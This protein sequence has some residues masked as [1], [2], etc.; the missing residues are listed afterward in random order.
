MELWVPLV[1]AILWTILLL[2]DIQGRPLTGRGDLWTGLAW[3]WVVPFVLYALSESIAA[4]IFAPSPRWVFGV[5]LG[6]FTGL[7]CL[8]LLGWWGASKSAE[9]KAETERRA[10]TEILRRE[11]EYLGGLQEQMKEL[12]KEVDQQGDE[13]KD[14]LEK[15]KGHLEVSMW[16]IS[17]QVAE[18]PT[19]AS[20]AG[21][22]A[23]VEGLDFQDRSARLF[24]N[25]G[26]DVDNKKGPGEPDHVLRLEGKIVGVV[27]AKY[28]GLKDKNWTVNEGRVRP[29]LKLA[30]EQGVPLVVHVC[31]KDNGRNWFH[32]FRADELDEG[33]K[34][35]TPDWLR[36]KRLS[37][38]GE[39]CM[40]ENYRQFH[41]FVDKIMTQ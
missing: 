4:R 17:E 32:V 22:R 33:C 29:E 38:R 7:F 40:M 9:E 15:I 16:G 27:A 18:L 14:H 13:L 31:N 41:E 28:W 10:L 21:E 12:T 23:R 1:F 6:V 19:E 37:E 26:F 36:T 5:E 24:R 34:V 2:R 3:G 8:C 39:R 35:T 25:F 30:R 20:V 11:E